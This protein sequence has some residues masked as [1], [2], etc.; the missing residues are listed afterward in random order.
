MVAN[1]HRVGATICLKKNRCEITKKLCLTNCLFVSITRL[2][3][4]MLISQPGIGEVL[5]CKTRAGFGDLF[6]FFLLYVTLVLALI[7][8]LGLTLFLGFE[9]SYLSQGFQKPM[10]CDF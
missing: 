6:G 1:N 3:F 7:L 9:F 5:G 10:I 8:G 4:V 2:S